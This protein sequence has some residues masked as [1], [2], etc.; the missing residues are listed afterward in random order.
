MNPI[1]PA[2]AWLFAFSDPIHVEK[3]AR[4]FLQRTMVRSLASVANALQFSRFSFLWLCRFV[5]TVARRSPAQPAK[6]LRMH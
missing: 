1:S 2:Y 4:F 3:Y 5:L 6:A